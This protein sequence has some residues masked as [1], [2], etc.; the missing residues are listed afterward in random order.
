LASYLVAPGS[1]AVRPGEE[2][3]VLLRWHAAGGTDRATVA[4][5]AV[6]GRGIVVQDGRPVGADGPDE[7]GQPGE[8]HRLT[9]PPRTPPGEYRLDVWVEEAGNRLALAVTPGT[10]GG[11][12]TLTLRAVTIEPGS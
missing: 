5:V 10:P 9:V 2:I 4:L 7:A 6:D 11:A 3:Q 12:G 8:I 1:G